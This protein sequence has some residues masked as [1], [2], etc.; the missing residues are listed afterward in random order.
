M[1]IIHTAEYQ[2]QLLPWQPA[3]SHS[4]NS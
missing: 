4:V 1:K 3:H 2:L